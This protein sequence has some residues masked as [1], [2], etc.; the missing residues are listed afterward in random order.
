VGP[1]VSASKYAYSI[2]RVRAKRAFMLKPEDYEALLRAPNIHQALAHLRS[3]SDFGRDIPQTEDV[4]E[5]EKHLANRFVE[6]LRPLIESVTEGPARDFLGLVLAKYEYE[7]LKALLK[8]KFLG[9][10]ES[11]VVLMAPPLGRYS[12]ALYTSLLSAK[13]VDQA[14]DLVP[15]AELRLTLREALR[16]AGTL[17][18]P[19]PIEATVD[20]WLYTRLWGLAAK[21]RGDDKKWAKHLLGIEV[22]IKNVLVLVRGKFLGLQPSIIEKAWL[23]LCYKLPLD[24]KSLASQP[25]SSILQAIATSYYGKAVSPL[26]RDAMEVERALEMLWIKE[27]EDVFLHYPFT[28]GL[29]YAYANLKYVELKD[30]RALLLSKLMNLPPQKALTL[31]TRY[32]ERLSI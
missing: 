18:S 5:I 3:I 12:G 27:N 1:G 31:I 24:L 9:I 25:I 11:E 4:Y 6:I 19:L 26:A 13:N 14:I 7:T 20:R 23:P 17:K 29:V 32:R 15:E 21:L 10:P 2:A 8:A 30:V 16:E 22:D 28:L